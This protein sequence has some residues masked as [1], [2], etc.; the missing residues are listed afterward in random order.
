MYKIHVS[1]HPCTT[2]R[3]FCSSLS[4]SWPVIHLSFFFSLFPLSPPQFQLAPTCCSPST[5]YIYVSCCFLHSQ[6]F[7][8]LRSIINVVYSAHIP[9]MNSRIKVTLDGRGVRHRSSLVGRQN[10]RNADAYLK[11]P[12]LLSIP[13]SLLRSRTWARH[14][15]PCRHWEAI[16]MVHVDSYRESCWPYM[17]NMNITSVTP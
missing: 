7:I 5:P 3:L 9:K 13:L 16:S 10:L 14:C 6:C 1:L 11:L 15:H 4:L 2:S 12:L 17:N 8:S